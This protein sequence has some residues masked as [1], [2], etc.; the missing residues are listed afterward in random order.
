[1]ADR[2]AVNTI[3]GYFYQFDYSII[4]IL[5]LANANDAIVV[6]GIE[7]VDIT[8][9]S[10]V[11]AIQCKYQ[12]HTEYNHSVIAPAIRLMLFH[13]KAVVDGKAAPIKY[14]LYGHFK[15]GQEKLVLPIN[16][17]FLKSKFLSYTEKGVP[18]KTYDE[19][20]LT[21]TQLHD[22][23][24]NLCIYINAIS[25]ESQFSKL[26]ELLRTQFSC[27]EF[28][29]EMLYYCNA[30]SKIKSLAIEQ[31][32]DKRRITKQS[33][34]NSIDV[35]HILFNDW[36]VAF[37]GRK[38]W[39]SHLREQYFSP[40]N[41]SPFER[42]FLVE[43]PRENYSRASLKEMIFHLSKKWSKLSRREN[44]PF[45]PYLYLHCIDSNELC[46]IKKELTCEDFQFI[47]GYDYMGA[48]FNPKSITRAATYTNQIKIK[49]V[50][51]LDNIPE[52][53][54]VTSKTKEIYQFY[55]S[56]PFFSAKYDNIAQVSIQIKDL[57]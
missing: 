50:N 57:V 5:E 34:I 32:D 30:L 26:I 23:L 41:I 20:G 18:R 3:R 25:F 24:G 14:K 12:E 8:S 17:D 52:I 31:D 44:Q 35:K 29:A 2:S 42:F 21:D 38:D 54:Q 10:E 48:P 9:D 51:F 13:Y 39:L 1:M 15:A 16:V 7:D 43:V 36:Y 53:I 28:D 49:F 56:E 11:T 45:C 40:L 22:F 46:V 6:E 47:D 4:Q 55:F 19:L 33:F 27:N 37:K